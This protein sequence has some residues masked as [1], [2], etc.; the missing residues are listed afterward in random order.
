MNELLILLLS[1]GCLL[2]SLVLLI[3]SVCILADSEREPESC[4]WDTDDGEHYV[5]SCGMN[6]RTL[7]LLDN[8]QRCGNCGGYIETRH[9]DFIPPHRR[10]HRIAMNEGVR[11]DY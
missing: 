9:T 2:G 7:L 4:M 8:F 1:A 11:D 10:S 6:Y 3:W 5:S